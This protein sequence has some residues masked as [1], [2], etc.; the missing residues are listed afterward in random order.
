LRWLPP[1]THDW[2][3]FLRPSEFVLGLRRNGI[4]ATQITGVVYDARRAEWWLS[5]DLAVN[6]MIAA[7]RR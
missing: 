7:V 5:P 6:Y 1:G 2:S 4:V 3:R